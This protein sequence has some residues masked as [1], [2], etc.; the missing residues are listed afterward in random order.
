MKMSSQSQGSTAAKLLLPFI[1]ILL[2][3]QPLAACF[4]WQ[5]EEDEMQ[6]QTLLF[7]EINT[8]FK[9]I[10]LFFFPNES[11]FLI[12]FSHVILFMFSIHKCHFKFLMFIRATSERGA[13]VRGSF[14][15][16]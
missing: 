6:Q 15:N 9:S 10:T 16:E 4:C 12:S 11:R 14:Y 3:I 2:A 8:R 5:V 1:L 13:A 7:N